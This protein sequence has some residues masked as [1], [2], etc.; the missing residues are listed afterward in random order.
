MASA[1]CR[2]LAGLFSHEAGAIALREAEAKALYTAERDARIRLEAEVAHLREAAVAAAA[3]E[4][5]LRA[6]VRDARRQA[7]V[8]S[9]RLEAEVRSL[10]TMVQAAVE[11][12][13]PVSGPAVSAP[14]AD[15]PARMSRPAVDD[16]AAA[17]ML[18]EDCRFAA[19]VSHA[20][21][22]AAMEARY[23]PSHGRP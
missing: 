21:A 4:A 5:E 8:T 1:F 11:P 12:G 13:R 3:R 19:F 14:A 2:S 7:E 17:S 10:I 22:D 18:A 23:L 16:S 15:V 6:D 9:A 20:K